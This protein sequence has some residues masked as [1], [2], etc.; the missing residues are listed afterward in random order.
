M[1][2]DT[3]VVSFMVIRNLASKDRVFYSRFYEDFVVYLKVLIEMPHEQ[4]K[5]YNYIYNLI[6]C[7]DL[8]GL[9]CSG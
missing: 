8:S 6:P 4:D 3:G 1:A 5:A 2:S 9:S 7:S